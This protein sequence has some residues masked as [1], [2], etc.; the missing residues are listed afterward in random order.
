MTPEQ[1]LARQV[2]IFDVAEPL[3]AYYDL[4]VEDD[5]GVSWWG[6]GYPELPP[7][8]PFNRRTS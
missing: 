7:F 1:A 8:N 4:L 2:A 6:D 5:Q 3:G